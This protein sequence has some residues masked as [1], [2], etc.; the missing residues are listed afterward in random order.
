[1]SGGASTSDRI[2]HLA[3]PE[4]W[5]EAFST[6][7]Y[8]MSTRGRTLEE[9]GFVHASSHDQVEATANRFYAD[10]D[11]LVLLT[12]DTE[13][14]ESEVRWEPPT[15]DAEELFPHVYGPIPVEAVVSAQ[16]WMRTIGADG[17][18]WDLTDL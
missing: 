17:A 4:D 11:Q 10:V 2:H 18:G 7:E 15:P 13:R 1:M 5:A 8:R 12:I 9:E 14:L 16:F 3:L 6:G